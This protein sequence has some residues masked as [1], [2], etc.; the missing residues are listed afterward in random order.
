MSNA[1]RI[2]G[3]LRLVAHL[4]NPQQPARHVAA[5]LR[6]DTGAVM[7]VVDPRIL[8]GL[9]LAPIGVQTLQGVTGATRQ[10]PLYR[11][12]LDLG[13]AGC[14]SQVTVAGIALPPAAGAD[15]LFGDNLLRHGIL[16]YNGP[17]DTWSFQVPTGRG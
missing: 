11:I 13:A 8:T 14:L 6:I 17:A 1:L 2:T 3:S 4:R 12:D 5:R 15:G 10:A 16:L 9:G 7:A